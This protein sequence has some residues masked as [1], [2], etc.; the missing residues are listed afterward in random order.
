MWTDFAHLYVVEKG[1]GSIPTKR[2]K[3]KKRK[4]ANVMKSMRGMGHKTP[5]GDEG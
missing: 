2:S 4:K 1:N 5:D 3:K